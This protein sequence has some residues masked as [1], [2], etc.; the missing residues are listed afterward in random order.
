MAIVLYPGAFKPPHRGHFELVKRLATNRVDGALYNLDDYQTAGEKALKGDIDVVDRITKVFVFVGSGIRNGI[1]QEDAIEVWKIYKKYLPGNVEI[2]AAKDN[3]MLT[4]RVY[5]KENSNEKFYAVTGVRSSEDFQD[6]RR[7][8]A[9][10]NLDNVQG[11]VV[12]GGKTSDVRATNFRNAIL[13]GSL[14]DVLDFFPK[15]LSREEI[16]K[17]IE[18]F[19]QGIIAEMMSEK[20]QDVYSAFFDKEETLAEGSSGLPLQNAAVLNSAQKASLGDLY[21]QIENLLG[22]EFEAELNGDRIVVKVKGSNPYTSSEKPFDYTPYMASILEYMIEEGMQIAPL[23]DVIVKRDLDEANDFFGKTAYYNPSEQKVVLYTANRHPKDVMRSFCHEM[24]HHIQ[25]VEGRLGNR[26][27]TD[28]TAD[29]EL[30]KIE[31]EAY[32]KGNMIF[33]KWEDSQK[34]K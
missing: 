27:T 16:L 10:K 20:I 6:L 17:I 2:V 32:L 21:H 4:A 19:K 28:T 3:P 9:F 30:Q 11:L 5:A 1:D 22:D 7:V 29:T 33:R 24:I 23:P 8:A 15:E 12:T 26:H 18:M 14:D 31:E 25:N 13:N 34:N